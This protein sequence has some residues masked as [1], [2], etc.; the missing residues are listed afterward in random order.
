LL[1]FV[2]DADDWG[3][4]GGLLRRRVFVVAMGQRDDDGVGGVEDGLDAAVVLFELEDLC[5]GK[6][7]GS[8][9]CCGRGGAEE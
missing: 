8:R 5:A 9:G 1:V 3:F 2:E 4:L 7:L 6:T